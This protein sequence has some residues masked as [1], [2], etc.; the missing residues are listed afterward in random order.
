MTRQELQ[1]VREWADTQLAAGNDPMWVWYQYMKLREALDGIIAGME[2]EALQ[3]QPIL[4]VNQPET[5]PHLVV[6]ND[7][8][9]TA[10]RPKL[11][12]VEALPRKFGV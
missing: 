8:R 11:G 2:C 9:E 4:P 3:S 10:Q 5:G 7:R 1:R 6:S 12:A